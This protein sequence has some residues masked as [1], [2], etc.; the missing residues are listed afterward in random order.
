MSKR[1]YVQVLGQLVANNEI[2]FWTI[3]HL[4]APDNRLEVKA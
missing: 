4:E 1:R 3:D 2:Y